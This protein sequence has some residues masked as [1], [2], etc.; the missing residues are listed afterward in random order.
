MSCYSHVIT[1]SRVTFKVTKDQRFHELLRRDCDIWM[2]SVKV[3]DS[4]GVGF[5]DTSMKELR[6][7]K[8]R[9]TTCQVLFIQGSGRFPENQRHITDEAQ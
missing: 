8:V 9:L 5:I 1:Y 2:V 7:R 4:L 6:Q 3:A